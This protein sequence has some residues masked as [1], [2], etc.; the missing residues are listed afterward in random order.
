MRFGPPPDDAGASARPGVGIYLGVVQFLFAATWIVYV[1]YLPQLVAQAGLPKQA[2]AWILMFDQL[3]FV[4]ADY[5]CG[6]AADRAAK[7]VG[8]VGI[9]VMAA[10][11]VSCAAFVAMPHVA[12]QGSAVGLLVLITLWAVTSSALRAPPLALVGRYAARP[13]Q[14]LLLA[15]TLLGL[16]IAN[17]LQPYLGLTLRDIDPR[18]PFALSSVSLALV[19]LGMVIAERRLRTA[20]Q[21]AAAAEPATAAPVSEPTPLFA[22]TAL[23]AALAFQVH[24]FIDSAVLYGAKADASA[25]PTL[26][27]VFWIS[28]SIAMFPFS[29]AV[30]RWA[31]TQVM[32]VAA[33]VA[34]GAALAGN[35]APTLPLLIAA[36]LLAGAA[37]AGVLVS[38]FAWALERGGGGRAGTYAGVLS[39]VLALAALARMASVSAGLPQERIYGFALLWWPF[40]GWLLASALVLV[41]RFATRGRELSPT[42]QFPRWRQN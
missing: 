25:L 36:Q 20:A 39:S 22:L 31:S 41:L 19:T 30:K 7:V 37:W 8:R 17:A 42:T 32:G 38:A 11:L 34:A 40:I 21:P 23:L 27:P 18:I 13:T 6:V 29:L 5:A 15:C 3:V 16:G 28:F 1:I 33:I 4:F 26:L 9:A 10:T 12:P 35:F 24:V 2:V 14:P